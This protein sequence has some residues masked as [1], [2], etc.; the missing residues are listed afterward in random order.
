MPTRFVRSAFVLCC[1]ACN[2]LAVA[3]DWPQI[4]GQNRN[5]IAASD[6]KLLAE[7]PQDGP[8]VLWERKVGHSYGGIAV[9]DGIAV[10]FHRRG[11]GEVIEALDA[12][13]GKTLWEHD[14]PTT[15]HPQ[16]GSG[17]GP[18]CVPTIA[19]E[20]VVT[21]GAQGVLSCFDLKNG[22]QHWQLDTHAKYR[23]REGY[24]GAGSSPIVIEDLVIVNVGGS[25]ENAGIVAFSLHDGS[26]KWHKNADPASYS[27]PTHCLINGIEHLVIV[28]RYHCCVLDAKTGALRFEFPFGQRGPTV[29]GATP[30]VVDD[31]LLVTSSYG[32]GS[33][34]AKFNLLNFE[35]VWEG[36]REMASQYCTPIVQD[37]YIYVIDGRDDLPPADLKCLELAT[38][39]VLWTEKDFGY[40]TLL[41]ADGKFLICK[42]NGELQLATMSPTGMKMLAKSRPLRGTVRALPAL[43]EGRLFIRDQ[44]TLKCLAVAPGL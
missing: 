27:A 25:R 34:Y 31:H 33:V 35:K 39:K 8:K 5:G 15:F 43:S 7:W 3:G 19:G 23:A 38:G 2:T 16:V 40:G 13:T 24:F 11:N 20:H 26:V 22:R 29:N 9:Q 18:L 17:N 10:L 1:I 30:V 12:S 42:T 36:E 21:Y 32:I 28:T 6:E 14:Y 4:L 37:G 41:F 44:D